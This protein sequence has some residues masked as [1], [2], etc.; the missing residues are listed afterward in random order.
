MSSS[1]NRCLFR[2]VK[3]FLI[4][5]MFVG[6]RH[7]DKLL[8]NRMGLFHFLRLNR[9]RKKPPKLPSGSTAQ[10]TA[11][12]TVNIFKV[13]QILPSLSRRHPPPK[14]TIP[15][16]AHFIL[17]CP[18]KVISPYKVDEMSFLLIFPVFILTF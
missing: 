14:T 12:F 16:P 10:K 3:Y 18:F 4:Y 6:I 1:Y 11:C 13:I 2:T 5:E 8:R 9:L 15:P 17:A 7:K